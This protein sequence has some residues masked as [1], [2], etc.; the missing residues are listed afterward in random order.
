MIV[1]IIG[2]GSMGKNHLKTLLQNDFVDEILVSDSNPDALDKIVKDSRITCLS[3]DELK[4][5]SKVDYVVV[6][7]PTKDHFE[8]VTQI[9][10]ISRLVL[11]EKPLAH[12]LEHARLMMRM[13]SENNVHI[14][15]GHIER[16]NPAILQLKSLLKQGILGKIYLVQTTRRGPR[17]LRISDVGVFFDLASHDIDIIHFLFEKDYSELRSHQVY[18]A[19]NTHEDMVVAQGFLTDKTI[20]TH[21]VNWI[22]PSKERTIRVLGERG[23]ILVD[24]LQMTVTFHANGSSL[25]K[26]KEL[27]HFQG[28][29]LGEVTSFAFEKFEPL[30]KQHSVIKEALDTNF[31]ICNFVTAEDGFRVVEILSSLRENSFYALHP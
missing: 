27:S 26:F 2:I 3:L 16:F 22:S 13:Q 17:P 14:A 1:A 29:F 4:K 18:T 31:D 24:A 6:S 15:V 21:N 19:S 30:W 8:I 5:R 9:S 28:N 12:D 11:V 25:V 10:S 23:E 20:V 7:V